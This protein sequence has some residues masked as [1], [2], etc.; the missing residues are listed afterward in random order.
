MA[1]CPSTAPSSP[2][3]LPVGKWGAN[4]PCVALDPISGNI[5]QKSLGVRKILAARCGFT[6]PPRPKRA[7]NEEK[8]YKSVRNLKVGT[9][10]RGGGVKA[11]YGRF[12]WTSGRF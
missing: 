12:L 9:F 1:Q 4:F 2:P 3:P 6:P 5:A 8:L 11:I 7:Q 10:S